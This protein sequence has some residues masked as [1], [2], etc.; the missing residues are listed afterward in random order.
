M[1]S[2][3]LKNF[4]LTVGMVLLSFLILGT[5]FMSVSYSFIVSD[6]RQSLK[7]T[8]QVIESTISAKLTESELDDWNLRIIISAIASASNVEVTICNSQGTIVSSSDHRG[9]ARNIGM[10]IPGSLISSLSSSSTSSISASGTLGGFF[11]SPRQ[12]YFSLIKNPDTEATEGYVLTSMEASSML[13]IWRS[14]VVIFFFASCFVLVLSLV[15]SMLTTG[16][17]VAP[18]KEMAAASKQFARGDF[19]V[20]VR[21]VNRKD[22]I[23]ELAAAFNSMADSL[24]RSDKLRSEFIANISHELKTPMTTITGFIDGILDGTIPPEKQATYLGVISSEARRLSRLVRKMLELSRLR[25]VD[26]SAIARSSF[27]IKNVLKSTALGLEGKAGEKNIEINMLIPQEKVIVTGD[28]DSITQ[29]IYNILDNA[30]KFSTPGEPITLSIWKQG[31]KAYV[32]IKNRGETIPASELPLIFDRFHKTDRSRGLDKDG[33]GLGL[34]IVKTII[35]N[36][37]ENVYVTSADGV[38][39]FVF[40]LGLK[41]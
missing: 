6:K 35:D 1:K 37:N 15:L 5:A 4:M 3:Y 10:V 7:V 9:Y 40:T 24:E 27:D 13:Q 2:I 41:K 31:E 19:S 17:Q 36:H 14:F 34:Y 30:I 8:S 33:V 25:S 32:S 29:V 39:E 18:L 20:R 28:P 12:Y 16:R 26:R 21:H 38:T 23:G 11:D 22:E